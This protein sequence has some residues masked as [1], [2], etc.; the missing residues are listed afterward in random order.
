MIEESARCVI[1]MGVSG[2]GKTTIAEDLA[3]LLGWTYAEGDDFHPQANRD[4]M[5]S[6]TPLTDEDR[7]P[8]LRTI[9]DWISAK[10]ESGES[11]V[12]TCSALRRAYREVL[13]AGNPHVQFC[14]V[15]VSPIELASR[16]QER[17]GHYMPASLLQSQLD[18][19]EPL[20]DDEP[21]ITVVAEG[22]PDRV[23]EQVVE[24][25]RASWTATDQA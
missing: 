4:K 1:V 20:G 14:H 19:L 13:E 11:A 15:A 5:A 24:E 9:A 8:W 12:V 16:M 3:E 10:G 23:F 18:T 22:P 25:L 6:G 2:S 7:W 21:G 17:E